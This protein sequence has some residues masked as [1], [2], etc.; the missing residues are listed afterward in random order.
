MHDVCF[1]ASGKNSNSDLPSAIWRLY[2]QMSSFVF[3]VIV[4]FF[5]TFLKDIFYNSV[6]TGQKERQARVCRLPSNVM[7]N[8]SY[9][10]KK[11]KTCLKICLA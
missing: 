10:R 8:L 6:R 11:L 9:L 4:R 5:P 2:A 1:P 7:L 3:V